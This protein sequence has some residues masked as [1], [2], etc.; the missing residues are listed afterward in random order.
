MAVGVTFNIWNELDLLQRWRN[1]PSKVRVSSAYNSWVLCL[2]PVWRTSEQTDW[3]S[4]IDSASILTQIYKFI[5]FVGLPRLHLPVIQIWTNLACPFLTI[6]NDR[7]VWLA[8][9]I[10]KIQWFI[11]KN[12]RAVHLHGDPVLRFTAITLQSSLTRL[13]NLSWLRGEH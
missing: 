1:L 13:R 4:S 5:Y 11:G 6:L 3:H 7:R 10:R 12:L 9:Q 8:E 2:H